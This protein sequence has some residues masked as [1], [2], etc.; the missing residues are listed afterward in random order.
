MLDSPSQI[1]I[2]PQSRPTPTRPLS[3]NWFHNLSIG[4]KQLVALLV[5]ELI[6]IIGLGIGSSIVLTNSL[7]TQL[8]AQAKSEVAVTETN[9]NIKINQMGFGSRGQ[10]DNP[11][12]IAATKNH[13]RNENFATELQNQLQQ[14]LQNEVKARRMEYATLIGKDLRIIA[15]A[16][17]KRSKET[18]TTAGLVPLIQQVL[19]DG[20]QVK[21]STVVGWDEIS[22]EAP[23]LPDGFTRQDALIRYVV[24]PVRDPENSDAVIGVLVFGDIVNRKLPIVENTLK[25]FSG[26]Y[27][28]VYLRRDSGEFNLATALSKDTANSQQID[29]ALYDP[30]ILK[31]AIDAKG[32]AVTQRIDINGQTYTVAAK[33]LPSRIVETPEGSVPVID[34]NPSAILVRGTPENALNQL[35]FSSMQQEA[36]VFALAIA[37]IVAWTTIFRRIVLKPIQELQ[38]TTEAFTN[39][40][41][42][43]RARIFAKDEVGQLAIAFNRMADS[44]N[45]S[46]V[47]LA[48]EVSRQEQ[49]TR[50]I[51]AL[52]EITIRMRRS[53][54]PVQIHQTAIDEARNFLKLDRVV[55]YQF[56]SDTVN[57]TVIAESVGNENP[58]VIGKTIEAPLGFDRFEQYSTQSAWVIKDADKEI[59]DRYRQHLAALNIKAEIAVSLKQENQ[60]VG[61]ICAQSCGR[62]RDWESSEINFFTQLVVQIGYALDQSK[63]LQERQSALRDAEDRKSSLQQQ[64]I[65]LLSEIQ[66]VSMGDLTVRAN[67]TADDLGTVANFFNAVVESLRDLVLKVKHTSAQVGDLL[68]QNEGEVQHLAAQ[69]R[70]QAQETTRTLNSV[71]QMTLSMQSVADR[72]Q[73]A[74][75]AAQNATNAAKSGETVMDST[76]T[77]IYSLRATV[78]DAT[79]K[80][81]QL[82]ESSQQ[83]GRVVSLINDLATQTDLLA[84]N[85]S[86]EATRAGEHGRGFGIV[87]NEIG[88]LASRS[89]TATR[90]I[91]TSI[92]TIQ[93][94][95]TEVVEAMNRGATQAVEGAHLARNAKQN[96]IHVVQVSGQMDSLVNSISEAMVSQ[97]KTSRSVTD[98]IKDVAQVSTLTSDSS[99]RVSKALRQTVDVAEELQSSVGMFKVQSSDRK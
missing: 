10:S 45:A 32:E 5:C 49:Q 3:S 79:R 27:S 15:N 26:G 29:V 78:E 13:Q 47:S 76:V 58:S 74:A 63:L 72:A 21:A 18:V 73:Q 88:E 8:L 64:I 20:R 52:S 57:G 95:I 66:N 44:I 97:A 43:S 87:A 89:A 33:A 61:L 16:N 24:T 85:A 81:K 69:A 34:D 62:D 90:E 7:R 41:R 28:A 11:A 23:P 1:P 84:I 40:D 98:L 36:I 51:R 82:G 99:V 50:E 35:L 31:S 83:I 70:Q 30:A 93:Q 68:N 22:K 12:I 65:Q 75:I 71:E 91:A 9:Y 60:I 38:Q 67:A 39:G 80:V 4:R 19:K 6:P 86:I 55:V 37:A 46:K 42:E 77:S 56:L 17:N 25:A 14:I 96:L 2:A 53:L 94:Q 92:E 54:N 59:N 48:S